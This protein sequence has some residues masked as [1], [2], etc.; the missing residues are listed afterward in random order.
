MSPNGKAADWGSIR[1]SG[2]PGRPI[3]PWWASGADVTDGG[4]DGDAGSVG[5]G[6]ALGAAL[7]A[8]PQ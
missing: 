8:E 1:P 5:A 2:M 7:E 3:P 6:M 4:S